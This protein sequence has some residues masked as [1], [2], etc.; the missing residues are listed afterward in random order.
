MAEPYDA[1]K[2]AALQQPPPT[3]Q[4]WQAEDPQHRSIVLPNTWADA[5]SRRVNERL[6][7][8]DVQDSIKAHHAAL[9]DAQGAAR[10]AIEQA[11]LQHATQVHNDTAGFLSEAPNVLN[12][13]NPD[14][15]KNHAA[16]WKKYPAAQPP[17]EAM[18]PYHVARG[19]YLEAHSELTQRKQVD[20]DNKFIDDAV[21]KGHLTPNDFAM[22]QGKPVNPNLFTPEGTINVSNA[23]WL[24]AT[25][26]G[27][28]VPNLNE[29]EKGMVKLY[30]T[31][32]A[33]TSAYQKLY[34]KATSG[35]ADAKTAHDT[36]W[37][38]WKRT[39]LAAPTT[40]KPASTPAV[41]ADKYFQ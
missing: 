33:R 20:E 25:R 38:I 36:V 41:G 26:A 3:L 2:I 22:S 18:E 37:N 31:P 39:G 1:D 19:K 8:P 9:A 13:N 40:A 10:L 23:R 21:S 5:R 32:D 15:E 14:Y 12:A 16:L 11:T 28:S 29:T 30:G 24:A 27:A 35:D 6:G 4:S 34:Q 17:A 7:Q